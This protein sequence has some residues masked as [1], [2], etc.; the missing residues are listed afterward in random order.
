M[1]HWFYSLLFLLITQAAIAQTIYKEFEV[2]SAAKPHGGLPLLEKFIDVNRRMPYAAEVARVKGTVILSMVIEPN[3]TVSEIAVLRSLRPDCDREAIRLLRSFKAW[4]PALKAGQSVRQSLTY[5]IRF[6]PSATQ[7]EPGAITAYYG[8]DGSA[9]AGEAQ[10]QFKLMTPVDT[11]GL[12]NGNPVISERKGNKWQKTVEN[13]FERIPYNRANEDDPSLPDSIPAIRLAIKDP[14]Y[15]FLNGTIYS[16]YPN[17][18]IMAREPYD[19]G[20]RIG[21]SIYYYRNGLVKLI[22]EI[23]PDGK[24]EEWAWHP[25]GQ[26]RHV[27]MRKLVAM[28]PEEIELFSQWD[29]TGKQLV[30]N[31][32][33]TARF[34]SRQD[35]KW[36]TETGLIKEQRKEGLWLGRFD[37]GKLAFRESYQNGKCESGVAYYESD[38][39]TYTD[40]NQNPEFQGGL[41]GLGRFLSANIRYPVDASRAGIQGKVFVSFVVCQDGSLCDYEVLR[42]VHPSVDNEALRVVKASNGKWKPGAIRG[43]QVRVK[44][45]LPINFHLQ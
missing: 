45:N 27:L 11:L 14:Q 13:S 37:D 20:R 7:S 5:T 21:R 30:Q 36:V 9:V 18:V 1:K 10:A 25:N 12:P 24:T 31:G 4:K 44:Y 34:L 29:S 43:K 35:G 22:S 17:G 3:G 2:D 23:R 41:N 33:G 42:G 15:Q 16:L 40:P 6:T 39:L 32:Q 38:S 19:D 28:S 26:L 8:K